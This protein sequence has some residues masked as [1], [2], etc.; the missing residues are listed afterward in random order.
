[1]LSMNHRQKLG[2]IKLKDVHYA[3][4]VLDEH[5]GYDAVYYFNCQETYHN[6]KEFNTLLIDLE[7]EP[8]MILKSFRKSTRAEIKKAL[9]DP[10]ISFN[11][12]ERPS[13]EEMEAFFQRI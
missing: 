12:S 8:E 10:E 6:A 3:T 7:P 4:E 13:D 5:P 9:D 1:M 2:F 11:L